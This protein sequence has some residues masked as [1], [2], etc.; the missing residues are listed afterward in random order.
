MLIKKLLL[1]ILL[2]LLAIGTQAKTGRES[3]TLMPGEPFERTI[4]GGGR[5]H[6]R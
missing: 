6:I 4:A 5:I 3:A 2:S 1:L